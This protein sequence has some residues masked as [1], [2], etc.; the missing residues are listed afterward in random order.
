VCC[1]R[2]K[3]F[4]FVYFCHLRK[5][6]FLPKLRH[7]GQGLFYFPRRTAPDTVIHFIL[8]PMM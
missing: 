7:R 4:V 6:V 2:N 8:F 3:K 1:I 5:V